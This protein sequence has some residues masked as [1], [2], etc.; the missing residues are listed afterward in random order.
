MKMSIKNL[1]TKAVKNIE[2]IKGGKGE[3]DVKGGGT[4]NP[5]FIPSGGGFDNAL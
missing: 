3:D 2:T 5:V 4:D 1:A